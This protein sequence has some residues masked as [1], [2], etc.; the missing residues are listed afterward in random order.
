MIKEEMRI[1]S[2]LP[3]AQHIFEMKLEGNIP[4]EVNQPGQFLH[5]KTTNQVTP[6]LRR[7]ISIC[8]N[9]KDK[10]QL[11]VIYRS[12]GQG[13]K[14]ISEKKIGDTIDVLGP[15]GNGFNIENVNRTDTV[16][17][18]GGGIGVPPLYGLGLELK[19]KGIH[20]VSVLGFST[21][22]A[23]FYH[24]KFAELG[25]VFY[26][27]MDGT[28]GHKGTVTDVMRRENI[29][30]DQLFACG[31]VPMLKSLE[32]TFPDAKGALSLEERM[33][34]GIGAC[35]AC[36]CHVQ[37]DPTGKDYRKVCSN[38]PVFPWREVALR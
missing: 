6:L 32:D 34:C 18:A 21:A 16:V 29:S 17:L 27:T 12:G 3:I 24:D 2:N 38:G 15:L 22:S 36:V 37:D 11:T 31:P 14:C 25:E 33:G 28:E 1:R 26:C 35:F 10:G 13:T 20:V 23:T 4:E 8:S 5:M 7:P 9:D 30:F 19:K